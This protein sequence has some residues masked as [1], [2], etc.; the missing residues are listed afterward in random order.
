MKRLENSVSIGGYTSN[1]NPNVH[2]IA[3]LLSVSIGGYTSNHNFSGE[4]TD[5]LASVSIGG[6][7]SNHN[8]RG[9]FGFRGRECF[10]WRLY[11]KP[12]RFSDQ[13]PP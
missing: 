7:T 12:Q 11:I 1:H 8:R 13:G 10:Y 4:M 3:L 9:S 2:F 6:Y 5:T